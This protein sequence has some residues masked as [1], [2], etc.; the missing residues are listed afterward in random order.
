MKNYVIILG[1]A[2]MMLLGTSCERRSYEMPHFRSVRSE[3]VMNSET[4]MNETYVY[5]SIE[6][7]YGYGYGHV[8]LRLIMSSSALFEECDTVSEFW[9]EMV[10]TSYSTRHFSI[11]SSIRP[12]NKSCYYFLE[13]QPPFSAPIRSEVYEMAVASGVGFSPIGL[14]TDITNHSAK[15][16][17]Q[18]V[19]LN[20]ITVE[21]CGIAWNKDKERLLESD[22]IQKYANNTKSISIGSSQKE[23]SA[24]LEKATTLQTANTLQPNTTYYVRAYAIATNGNTSYSD[25]WT[26]TTTK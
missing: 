25:T 17:F 19:S 24:L 1:A 11:P 7:D 16:S 14:I 22:Y 15:V 18:I 2:I 4:D 26:F 20:D 8:P 10:A 9:D 21:K 13:F 12:L 3:I 6:P 5:Y 23:Q